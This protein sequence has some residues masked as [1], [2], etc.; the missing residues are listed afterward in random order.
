MKQVGFLG[1]GKIGQALLKHLHE[2][3]YGEAVFIE[4]PSVILEGEPVVRAASEELYSR[5]QLVVECATADVLKTRIE[6]I[7]KYGDLL[8]FSVTAFSDP[9]FSARVKALCSQYGRRVYLPHG[10]ILGLDGI[11]DGRRVWTEVI[12]E[13][14]KSP[15]SL[16]R[17]DTSR[18]VVYEGPTRQVCSLYPR[19]V[20][21][22]AAIA[23]AGIGF[24]RTQSRIIS[25]PAVSTNAH[26]IRLKGEEMDITLN[27]SSYAAGAVTG[28]Y[29][30]YSACGSLD[31]I[32][33]REW[34]CVFV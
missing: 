13:T 24:D 34:G 28:A 6:W 19:N 17:T 18:V 2:Q 9:D 1:C 26:T 31:R 5:A 22:H 15:K 21:V 14:V 32:C 30:P 29:T 12:V 10:A 4:D 16:G 27:I 7:L 8:T 33:G 11:F 3:G 20:N 23:L 25:D